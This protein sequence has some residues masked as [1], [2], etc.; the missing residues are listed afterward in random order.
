MKNKNHKS[1][2]V[3]SLILFVIIV[4]CI[5]GSNRTNLRKQ[6][7][8]VAVSSRDNKAAYSYDGIKWT[9]VS[10]PSMS[11]WH[12]LQKL[13][14][15]LLGIPANSIVWS[16]VTYGN[17]KFVAIA[18]RNYSP[19]SSGGGG[20]LYAPDTA[21][22][23][24]DGIEWEVTEMSGGSSVTYGNNKFVTGS[25][26]STDGI[27]WFQTGFVGWTSACYGNG[28]F[29]AITVGGA[30]GQGRNND[31]LYPVFDSDL[32]IIYSNDGI[33]R[34]NTTAPINDN[35]S[36]VCYGNGKFVAVS[37]D[38]AAYSTDGIKWKMTTI[39][40]KAHWQGICYGKDKFVAI[41]DS[42]ND[43]NKRAIYSEDGIN[44]K[45][46]TMPGNESW[47]SICYGNDKFVVIS[48]YSNKAAYSYDGINWSKTTMPDE[49]EWSSVCY[50][51]D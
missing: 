21:A 16:S 46:A 20:S 22:Y 50:G 37:Y 11:W 5:S 3:L 40:V 23:S 26:H 42:I 39:P 4:G 32:R 27:K 35:W 31:P 29:V 34:I 7:K 51:G 1:K 30:G 36:R 38:K 9:A 19:F 24:Y 17:G 8:F 25:T 33:E 6:P 13:E 14:T 45:T 43:W 12:S 47:S 49:T 2:I 28:R 48:T 10:I 18:S 44:W 41:N 15:K